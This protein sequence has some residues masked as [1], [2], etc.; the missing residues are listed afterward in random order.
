MIGIVFPQT[1]LHY[2]ARMTRIKHVQRRRLK[3]IKRTHS[4]K[5]SPPQINEEDFVN[6]GNVGLLDA[7]FSVRTNDPPD[8]NVG[9]L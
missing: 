8:K 1:H 7:D 6:V 3:N 9:M 2:I 4:Y 5:K